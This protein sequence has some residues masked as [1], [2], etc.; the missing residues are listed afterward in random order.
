MDKRYLFTPGPTPVPPQVLAAMGEPVVHHRSPDFRPIYER[1][2]ARLRE[3]CRTESDVLLFTASGTGAFESAVVNLVSPGEPHLVVSAGSFG[4]RWVAMTSA[5]GA[6]VDQLRYEWGETPDPED[7]RARLA[8]RE[9]KA[10]WIVQS[11]TSTGVVADVQAIAAVAKEAGA[12]VVVDAVSSLGAVPCE[13]DAWGLDVV[14]SGSQKAL[15]TPPGLGLAA[16]SDAALAATGSTPRFYFDWQRT[17]D[18][19]RKLDA[20]FTP[21]VSLVT[22]LD[23]AL[24]MLLEEGLEAVFERHVR[25]GRAARAGAKAMG[26]ELFSPDEDRSAVV[27]AVLSPDA[28]EVISGVRNRFGIT[29]AGGQGDLKGKIFRIGH[30]G[31]FDVFD[32]TTALAAIEIMLAELGADIERGVAVTAALDAYEHSS[33]A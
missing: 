28:A 6:D 4:E 33:V 11:E 20:P 3:V 23:V 27:T 29:L 19:Q 2:L 14:V 8:A 1:C 32:I 21:P 13:T 12:L 17:R 5:Y 16:V 18:A 7:V 24:G 30:I 10:V 9:A 15:M 22:A 26:L 25:L 31:W